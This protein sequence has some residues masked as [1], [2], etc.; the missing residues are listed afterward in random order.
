M[1]AQKRTSA[2]SSETDPV[3]PAQSLDEWEV[4]LDQWGVRREFDQLISAHCDATILIATLQ[5]LL[6]SRAADS[7]ETLTGFH[8]R[9][10]G[11]VLARMAECANDLEKLNS[12]WIAQLLLLQMS[13]IE[14]P[15]YKVHVLALPKVLRTY[16][17][18]VKSLSRERRLQPRAKTHAD[19]ARGFLTQY[20]IATTGRPHDNEVA[21]L[22]SV[23]LNRPDL[24]ADSQKDWRRKHRE[25]LSGEAVNPANH[26]P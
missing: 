9:K 15:E 17:E 19:H 11:T 3:G 20:V 18:F 12:S 26:Q 25:L 4:R 14:H 16:R 22:L 10:L 24:T 6:E 2:Q 5:I 7:W 1:A 21:R 23:L 8:R 13:T